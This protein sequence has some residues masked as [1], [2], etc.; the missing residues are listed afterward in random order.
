M[1][2]EINITTL[3]FGFLQPLAGMLG[4][5]EFLPNGELTSSILSYICSDRSVIQQVC[6]T[7]LFALCG[8]DP[9]ELNTVS[10]LHNWR[11]S[12]FST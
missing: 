7:A 8:Y 4:I 12:P 2:M 10:L 3:I 1:K 6:S 5:K 9:Q 11:T